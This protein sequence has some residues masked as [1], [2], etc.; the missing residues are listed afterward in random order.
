MPSNFALSISQSNALY[1]DIYA[2]WIGAMTVRH[3]QIFDTC[4]RWDKVKISNVKLLKIKLKKLSEVKN[5]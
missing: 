1:L 3:Y 4:E 2:S 5:K